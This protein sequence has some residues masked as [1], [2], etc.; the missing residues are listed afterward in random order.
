[1]T[2]TPIFP[3][4]SQIPAQYHALMT[5]A[6]VF[7]S[8]CSPVA[9][10]YFIDRDNGYYLK[11]APKDSLASEAALTR[12]FHEK[13][14]ATEILDYYSADRD[15]MLS[16]AVPGEDCV[17]ADYLAEPKRLCDLLSSLLR[18]LHDTNAAGCPVQDHRTSYLSRTEEGY[19]SGTFAP[20]YLPEAMRQMAAQDVWNIVENGRHLFKADTLLHGDYCLPNIMLN[21]WKF[22]AFIDLG[23]G[24][25]GDRHVDLY[26]GA[27]SLARN[28]STDSYRNRFFDGYGRDKIDPDMLTIV[29]ACETFG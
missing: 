20:R 28:L 25:I 8:S 22:S 12:F 10:V 14:L 27:W 29:A 21:D 19:R 17:Y 7:D 5:S 16:A 13:G 11:S 2:R 18:N 24:G 23:N 15:W 26:W 1:M 3:D 4:L 6:P 9:T